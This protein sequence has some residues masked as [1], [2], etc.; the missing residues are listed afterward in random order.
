MANVSTILF[1]ILFAVDTNALVNRNGIDALMVIM[2][3]ELEKTVSWLSV[4]E[5]SLNI[6]K[7]HYIIFTLKNV[8][9]ISNICN[10][11]QINGI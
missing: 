4:N 9:K 3:E 1:P 11:M 7:T 8:I 2:N 10:D 6:K 5:L